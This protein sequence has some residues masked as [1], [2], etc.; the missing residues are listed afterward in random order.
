MLTRI[1]IDLFLLVLTVAI[2]A[3]VTLEVYKRY[4]YPF[5]YKHI[6]KLLQQYKK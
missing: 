1:I 6:T 5:A 4:L 2:L 3:G